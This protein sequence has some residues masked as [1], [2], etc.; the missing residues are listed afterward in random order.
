MNVST[1][2]RIGY[3]GALNGNVTANGT[4]VPVYDAY[5]IPEGVEYPYIII[6]SQTEVER[7]VKWCRMYEATVLIDIVTG[8]L[9]ISGRRQSEDIAAQIE[10][11]LNPVTGPLIDITANGYKIGDTERIFSENL[12][13]RND[14][15]YIYRKLLRYRLLVEKI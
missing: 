12:E 14:V 1:A 9:G 7:R 11:I 3:S 10:P 5:S 4:A 2:I 15:Y 13:D 6:S 8:S